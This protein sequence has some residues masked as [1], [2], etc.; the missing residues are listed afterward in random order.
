MR[1]RIAGA[2]LM[3]SWLRVADDFLCTSP[4]PPCRDTLRLER[5]EPLMSRQAE[6]DQPASEY[7]NFENALKTVLS[8][9]HSE[10]KKK[11]EVAKKRRKS[12]SSA[13]RASNTRARA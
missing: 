12:R 3:R 7:S 4:F 2:E 1:L 5:D 8:V 11:V 13:S 6:S 10:L 9:S